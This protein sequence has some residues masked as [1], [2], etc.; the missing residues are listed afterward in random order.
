LR[1]IA[2]T[3]PASGDSRSP[4]AHLLDEVVGLGRQAAGVDAEQA[5][6]GVDRI[7]HVEQ[8]RAVCLECRGDRDARREALDRPLEHD[9]RLLALE[10]DRQLPCFEIVK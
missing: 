10:L 9:L 5:D 8:H 6:R 3:G 7:R 4:V 1:T 2:L